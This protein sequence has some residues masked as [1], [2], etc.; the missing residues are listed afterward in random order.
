MLFVMSWLHARSSLM[1]RRQRK[2]RVTSL[3]PTPCSSP[4]RHY[5]HLM[6]IGCYRPLHKLYSWKTGPKLAMY[7][8]L[9]LYF[10]V[11][12]CKS[13]SSLP[14]ILK[15]DGINFKAF[16]ATFKDL[17]FTM[18]YN[19]GQHYLNIL[20]HYTTAFFKAARSYRN[21]QVQTKYGSLY[22]D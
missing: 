20:A 16:K 1:A 22:Q 13:F 12:L 3:S 18:S 4:A 10:C 19:V 5:C 8:S 2:H 14:F 17:P 15:H 21:S 6:V 7:F 9:C 11:Q